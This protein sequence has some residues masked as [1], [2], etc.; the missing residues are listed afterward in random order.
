MASFV[1]QFEDGVHQGGEHGSGS[2]CFTAHPESKER[3]RPMLSPLL[4]SKLVQDPNL[5]D[6]VTHNEGESPILGKT[7]IDTSWDVLPRPF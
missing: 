5:W 4:V 3:L 1:S 2:H 6:G 7:F